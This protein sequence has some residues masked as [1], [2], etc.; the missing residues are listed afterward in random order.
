MSAP[1]D[2]TALPPVAADP[3][4]PACAGAGFYLMA[5][6]YGHAD[7]GKL[8]PCACTEHARR[9]RADAARQQHLRD[10]HTALG[11]I[12]AEKTFANYDPN[13][14]IACDYAGMSVVEQHAQLAAALRAAEQYAAHLTGWLF[15]Y[16]PVGTGKSHLAAAIAN[17]VAPRGGSVAYATVPALL[18]FIRHGFTDGTS[19]AKFEALRTAGLLVLDDLGTEQATPWQVS[20]LLELFQHRYAHVLP[21][22]ITTNVGIRQL[23]PRIADRIDE[24]ARFVPM[25]A[26]SYR[27]ELRRL[28]EQQ[29]GRG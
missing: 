5:V 24:L 8:R 2:H 23:E 10:L 15:L 3:Q 20:T 1:V 27:A 28:R 7:W 26:K 25:I 16:G 13:R 17:A 11:P 21:T 18:R 4:C 14:A 19:E 12:L 6:P 9:V 22:V 29:D